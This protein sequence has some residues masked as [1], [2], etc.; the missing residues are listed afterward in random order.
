MCTRKLHQLFGRVWTRGHGRQSGEMPGADSAEALHVDAMVPG[1]GS[2][3]ADESEANVS[4]RQSLSISMK[5]SRTL[6]RLFPGGN[7]VLV[8]MPGVPKRAGF[9]VLQS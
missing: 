9:T 2:T 3:P 6:R 8:V 5:R 1:R 7:V 4:G